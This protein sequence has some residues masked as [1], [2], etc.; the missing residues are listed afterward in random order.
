M[1]TTETPEPLML[2]NSDEVRLWTQTLL[3]LTGHPL[4]GGTDYVL[5]QADLFVRAFR[6]RQPE[7]DPYRS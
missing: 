3:A 5:Q 4:N 2:N 1:S 6:A 7:K